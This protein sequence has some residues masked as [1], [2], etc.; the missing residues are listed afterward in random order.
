MQT[1]VISKL[2]YCNSILTA[3]ICGEAVRRGVVFDQPKRTHVTPSLVTLDWLLVASR[4]KFKSAPACLTAMFLLFSPSQPLCSS[5]ERLF[6]LF[7]PPQP[8][9]SSNERLFS[10]HQKSG[11]QDSFLSVVPWWWNELLISN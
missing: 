5:N 2:D 4:I 11:S 3:C 1:L 6:L 7:S 10:Q 8:L 9:C